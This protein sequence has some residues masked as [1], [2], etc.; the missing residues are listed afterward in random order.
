[1]CCV[2]SIRIRSV[3]RFTTSAS[4]PKGCRH[5]QHLQSLSHQK[6]AE[7]EQPEERPGSGP[8]WVEISW[9]EAFTTITGKLQAIRD[10]DPR[11]LIWQHGH[12]KYLIGDKF[13]KAF[14]TPNLVSRTSTCEAARHVADEL[15]WGNHGFLPDIEQCNFL[16]NFGGNYFEAEQFARWLDHASTDARERGMKVVVIEPRLSGTASKADE[17]LPIR[18]GK[19]MLLLGI[20]SAQGGS[21]IESQRGF[22]FVHVICM[23][24][25]GPGCGVSEKNRRQAQQA[26]QRQYVQPDTEQQHRVGRQQKAGIDPGGFFLPINIG[27]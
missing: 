13:P 7:A 27:R 8:G 5:F 1:M 26:V 10:D 6:A 25:G 16:L 2:P 12:G 20:R 22:Q 23:L 21:D 11:K 4:V 9:E 15:T 19:D 17:W 24:Q 18:P 14:G 3:P